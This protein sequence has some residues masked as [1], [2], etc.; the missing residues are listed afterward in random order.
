MQTQARNYFGLEN[1]ETR[2]TD[3]ELSIK[4]I[5]SEL[6]DIVAAQCQA[7]LDCYGVTGID[8]D[9]EKEFLMSDIAESDSDDSL[10]DNTEEIPSLIPQVKLSPCL[11]KLLSRVVIMV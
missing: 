2:A 7:L 10:V 1:M 9:D 8:S 11:S 4:E 6:E 5:N 3:V